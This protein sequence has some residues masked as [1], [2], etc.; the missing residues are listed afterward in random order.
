MNFDNVVYERPLV[1]W[2][3]NVKYFDANVITNRT[4]KRNFS[5]YL[6]NKDP[7]LPQNVI[8]AAM[9][10]LYEYCQRI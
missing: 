10:P 6:K 2:Y 1:P 4:I 9:Y 7:F 5:V 8:S 3:R